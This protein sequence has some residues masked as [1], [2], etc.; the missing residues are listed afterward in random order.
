MSQRKFT[1]EDFDLLMSY[2]K[3][4]PDKG[5]VLSLAN[6]ILMMSRTVPSPL[7]VV[8]GAG[9]GDKV[10]VKI[11]SSLKSILSSQQK[12][13]TEQ[14]NGISEVQRESMNDSNPSPKT[15]S[16]F[17]IVKEKTEKFLALMHQLFMRKLPELTKILIET[18]CMLHVNKI[19]TNPSFDI[20]IE[21]IIHR[22]P[23]SLISQ[24]LFEYLYMQLLPSIPQ[25]LPL[26]FW[27][28][29]NISDVAVAQLVSK[30]EPS[31]SFAINDRW[32]LWPIIIACKAINSVKASILVFLA[33]CGHE[34]WV[35][36]YST[37]IIVCNALEEDYSSMLSIFLIYL[38]NCLLCQMIPANAEILDCY[39]TLARHFLLFRDS[40][41]KQ[42]ELENAFR[43]S[44]F[45]SSIEQLKQTT[46][47]L[48][49][50]QNS[51]KSKKSPSRAKSMIP[52]ESSEIMAIRSMTDSDSYAPR[53][54]IKAKKF[55]KKIIEF[56]QLPY[57]YGFGLRL[58]E[59]SRWLDLSL[60][61]NTMH[62][63]GMTCYWPAF[64]IDLI[65]CSF[66]LRTIPSIV[67]THLNSLKFSSK[68]IDQYQ[69]SLKF[70]KIYLIQLKNFTKNSISLIL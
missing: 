65:I 22:L 48:V 61:Q 66:V 16:T 40:R 49:H 23:K 58:D 24:E 26:C 28:A 29:F 70:L 51:I 59:R 44:P 27:L 8:I 21:I 45:S 25:L 32:S 68:M 35:N 38:S 39:F 31:K 5:T 41:E 7:E 10:N 54:F 69:I 57:S 67:Q 18:I 63:V 19:L 36:V 56:N 43:F 4:T 14:D 47:S 1:L 64:D 62:L 11:G 46:S 9:D 20:H 33:K 15:S 50:D 6:L 3:E 52:S 34:E 12:Q 37:I 42:R 30:T 13:T 2:I 53:K 60:A 17:S 55:T